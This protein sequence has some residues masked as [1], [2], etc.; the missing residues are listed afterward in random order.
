MHFS[1]SAR[2]Q[3]QSLFT[4]GCIYVL[5]ACRNNVGDDPWKMLIS[6]ESLVEKSKKKNIYTD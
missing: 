2:G 3:S 5:I 4:I 1:A 6:V